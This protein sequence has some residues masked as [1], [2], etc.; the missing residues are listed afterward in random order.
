MERSHCP[1]VVEVINLGV[2]VNINQSWRQVPHGQCC[3]A[4]K[5]LVLA[6]PYRLINQWLRWI[7]IIS[8]S[9]KKS[10]SL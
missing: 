8:T 2:V 1:G 4:A 5:A 10:C 6:H 7:C 9:Q 3:L